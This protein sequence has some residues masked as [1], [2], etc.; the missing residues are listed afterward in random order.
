MGPKYQI[1]KT[2]EF[3]KWLG[4]LP[5]KTRAIVTSRLDQLAVGHFGNHKR[6]EG[7]IELKWLNG[8][9]V[10][11]FMWSNAIVVAL[12]GGNKNGQQKDIKKAIKIRNEILEGIRTILKP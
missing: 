5:P 8:I 6:F 1:I 4:K 9:R 7:L 2:A 12:S 11:S 10:Y 3:E